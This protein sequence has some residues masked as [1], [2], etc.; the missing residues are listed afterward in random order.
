M[1]EM[2]LNT[3][4]SL[5][6][7]AYNLIKRLLLEELQKLNWTPFNE[8]LMK[9]LLRATLNFSIVVNYCTCLISPFT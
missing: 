5:F 1:F 4:L 8:G 3:H 9:L 2:V 6:V 7:A